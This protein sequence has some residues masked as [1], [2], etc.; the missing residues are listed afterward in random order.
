MCRI[1]T[2]TPDYKN[3]A[4]AYSLKIVLQRVGRASVT[5]GGDEV[6]EI[7]RGALLLVGFRIGDTEASHRPMA[8]KILALRIFP[9]E[10]GRFDRS[11]CDIGGE[12]LIVSQFTLYGETSSGRRPDFG[13]ALPGDLAR[14]LYDSFAGTFPA[15]G[16]TKVKT[17]VFGASMLVSL[18]NDGPV[19]LI[20]ESPPE[21]V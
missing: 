5:V 9:N 2:R 11:I 14:S 1:S 6:A 8:E 15:L 4:A 21:R 10:S 18:E 19:T 17:G 16:F 12:L 20:L 7:G 3:R 13:T